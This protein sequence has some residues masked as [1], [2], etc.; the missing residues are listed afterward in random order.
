MFCKS[1]QCNSLHTCPWYGNVGWVLRS[2]FDSAYWRHLFPVWHKRWALC[3]KSYCGIGRERGSPW[4]FAVPKSLI[5]TSLISI[6]RHRLSSIIRLNRESTFASRPK[7]IM[8]FHQPKR[9]SGKRDT[10]CKECRFFSMLGRWEWR[11]AFIWRVNRGERGVSVCMH[12]VCMQCECTYSHIQGTN[13]N[14]GVMW[15]NRCLM[16]WVL[17]TQ[18]STLC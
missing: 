9:A 7:P 4:A 3:L 11:T 17:A 1:T 13:L 8:C 14:S 15:G 10:D 2:R 6:H 12:K 16:K 18:S 5:L